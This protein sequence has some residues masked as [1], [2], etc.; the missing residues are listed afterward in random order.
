MKLRFSIAAALAYLV[1]A[2]TAP[3]PRAEDLAQ[4][5]HLWSVEAPDGQRSFI[6]AVSPSGDPRAIRIVEKQLEYAGSVE[7]FVFSSQL[8]ITQIPAPEAW[9]RRAHEI[10]SENAVKEIQAELS[11]TKPSQDFTSFFQ[12][13]PV[14]FIRLALISEERPRRPTA[15]HRALS[16]Q[17]S[18]KLALSLIVET[19][20]PKWANVWDDL[21]LKAHADPEALLLKLAADRR[22]NGPLLTRLLD[23]YL[24]GDWKAQTDLREIQS[25]GTWAVSAEDFPNAFRTE[26]DISLWLN[27]SDRNPHSSSSCKPMS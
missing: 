27:F 20:M 5:H 14:E 23:I 13:F 1:F 3:S 2:A 10:L 25:L 9:S 18:R 19:S 21:R 11:R 16:F 7:R 22:A 8:W 24:K 6:A 4:G 12:N 15:G 26:E 17:F